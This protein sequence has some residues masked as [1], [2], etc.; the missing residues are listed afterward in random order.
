M[1]NSVTAYLGYVAQSL[2]YRA[3]PSLSL[4]PYAREEGLAKVTFD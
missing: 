2:V 4:I 1:R 3:R